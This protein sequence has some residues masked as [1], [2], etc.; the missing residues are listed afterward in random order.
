MFGSHHLMNFTDDDRSGLVDI[1]RPE[2][3][4]DNK[5]GQRLGSFQ[6]RHPRHPWDF[7]MWPQYSSYLSSLQILVAVQSGARTLQIVVLWVTTPRSLVR[8]HQR[9]TRYSLSR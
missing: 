1:G 9:C 3:G 2:G 6:R 7:L 8:V 4:Q 5:S